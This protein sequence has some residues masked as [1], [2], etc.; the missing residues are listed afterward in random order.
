[1]TEEELMKDAE[2][3]NPHTKF[4]LARHYLENHD[5]VDVVRTAVS[6]LEDAAGEGVSEAVL[7]LARKSSHFSQLIFQIDEQQGTD[8]LVDAHTS[9]NLHAAIRSR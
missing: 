6:L 4:L 5:E 9:D 3:G 8:C 7:L 1:M 2:G